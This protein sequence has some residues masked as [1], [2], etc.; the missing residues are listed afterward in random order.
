MFMSTTTTIKLDAT[1]RSLLRKLA[2]ERG[3]SQSEVI[4]AGIIA[5]ANAQ[6]QGA[7]FHQRF[8]HLFGTFE[9][10]TSRMSKDL[11][12]RFSEG[13][14][15]KHRRSSEAFERGRKKSARP[16]A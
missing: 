7:D 14:V 2:K 12:R 3:E 16:A 13:M 1:T 11:G 15:A 6:E 4:R 9:S 10:K 8:K 5:L